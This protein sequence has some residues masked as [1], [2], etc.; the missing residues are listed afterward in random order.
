MP[1]PPPQ[2]F[3]AFASEAEKFCER[4][5]G[6]TTMATAEIQTD[7]SFGRWRLSP[8]RRRLLVDGDQVALG[9][10]AFDILLALIE[11]RGSLVTKDALMRRVW[12]GTI[13][14]DNSL[15]VQISALRKALG[16]DAA[17]LIATIPGRGYCFTG[18]LHSQGYSADARDTLPTPDSLA[19]PPFPA[20]DPEPPRTP[21]PSGT[22]A[23]FAA[24][25][26]VLVILPFINMTSD[27]EQEYFADGITEELTTALSHARWFSV[28]ARNSAFTYKGR[29][30]DVRQVG[31][32]LGAGYVLE[33]SVRR[34][35][36]Q[37]RISAQLNETETGRRVW[38]ERLDGD[39]ADVFDLQDRVTEAVT[40]AIEPNL[41]LAEAERVRVKSVESLGAYDLYLRALLPHRFIALD[42]N[43]E[44][45]RLL[46]RAI[47]LAPEFTAAKGALG[48]VSVIRVEQGWPQP[49]I[50]QAIRYAREVVDAGHVD[51]PTALAWSAHALT[52]LGRDYEAGVAAAS[53]ALRLAPNAAQVLSL[54][55]WNRM[56]V[57]DWEVA[58]T[59]ISRAVQLSPVDP[60]LFFYS[61]ALSAA[62]FT[63]AQYED[64][65]AWARRGISERPT[66]L[67]AHRLLAANLALLG[68]LEAAN[69]AV[70]M[71]LRLAPG[72]TVTSIMAQSALVDPAQ[73]ER[74]FDALRRAG[75]PD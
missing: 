26:P 63:G 48:A 70:Q 67:L 52:Y 29:A 50:A 32:E 47:A 51:D 21:A 57:G 22:T 23:D 36:N 49:D 54:S 41:R 13:T 59:Q 62:Y 19:H 38:A 30:V 10:R 11:Q 69:D 55:G 27:P 8:A 65:V 39:F 15:Q 64:A 17:G 35:G 24:S 7:I 20:P 1:P 4:E 2:V 9:S 66:Y 74:Y 6:T 25:R 53:R 31:R 73:R 60:M 5:T 61:T 37:V 40:S 14:E 34:A 18:Q 42:S 58:I 28:I 71:F 75:L 44:A 46:R 43:D 68:R 72:E 56:Y 33:G 3:G 12:P 16:Q 45:L